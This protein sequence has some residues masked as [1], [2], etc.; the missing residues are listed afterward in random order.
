MRETRHCRFVEIFD[1]VSRGARA[2][3]AGAHF[4]LADDLSTGTNYTKQLFLV[5][6]NES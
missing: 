5:E 6:P 4:L 2:G 3:R 1:F